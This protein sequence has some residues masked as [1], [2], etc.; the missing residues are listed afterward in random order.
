MGAKAWSAGGGSRGGILL[1]RG[2][3][4]AGSGMCAE[5]TQRFAVKPGD[6]FTVEIGVGGTGAVYNSNTGVTAGGL[7]RLTHVRTGTVLVY[8]ALG[9][10]PSTSATG[11]AGALTTGSVGDILTAGN[12]G[13][14]SGAA[15]GSAGGVGGSAPSGGGTGGIGGDTGIL[16]TSGTPPGAGAGGGKG[17]NDTGGVGQGKQGS[18]G[19]IDITYLQQEIVGFA[20]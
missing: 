1:G 14:S 19:A 5:R 20:A 11:A 15:G 16:A 13:A 9:G 18:A 8:A 3:G 12:A 4:G 6:I 17:N 2:A 7:T 10:S